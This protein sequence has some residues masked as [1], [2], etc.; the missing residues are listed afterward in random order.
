MSQGSLAPRSLAPNASHRNVTTA[1]RIEKKSKA[2]HAKRHL[3]PLDTRYLSFLAER[4]SKKIESAKSSQA[5]M[6]RYAGFEKIQIS[7]KMKSS[8]APLPPILTNTLANQDS[9]N[10]PFHGPPAASCRPSN[11]F[12]YRALCRP[13]APWSDLAPSIHSLP[14]HPWTC[15]KKREAP[16]W[17]SSSAESHNCAQSIELQYFLWHFDGNTTSTLASF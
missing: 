12:P 5:Y 14:P 8:Q 4:R 16:C 15:L 3:V 11:S 17:C 9:Q 6:L 13:I 1:A 7:K 2:K 10:R